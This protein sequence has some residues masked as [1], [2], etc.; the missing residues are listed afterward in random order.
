MQA[1]FPIELPELD[2]GGGDHTSPSPFA[3]STEKIAVEIVYVKCSAG[4][5]LVRHCTV[6]FI[7]E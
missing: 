6:M 5:Y 3:C 7:F 2:R 1:L 4:L